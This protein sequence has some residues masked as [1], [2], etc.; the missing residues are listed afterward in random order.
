MN[1]HPCRLDFSSKPM[2]MGIINCTPDSFFPS[3]RT[4]ALTAAVKKA[5]EMIEEGAD[6]LDIGGE[7]SR[8]GADYINE[9]EELSRVIPAVKE[10]RKFSQIP[11]SIDTRK[12]EVARQA[13]DSGADI[14][15]DISALQDDA[16]LGTVVAG[17][18]AWIILM[19]KR[20]KPDTMQNNPNY[21][22][23]LA[24]IH[25]ELL[26]AVH[27]AENAG[28]S[29]KRIILDPGIGFGKRHEDNLLILNETGFFPQ[30]GVPCACRSFEEII[31]R[32]NNR[33]RGS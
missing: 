10:I 5:L 33:T 8:P 24:E 1:D 3:S 11:I 30:N 14:I 28:I 15:N 22:E 17:K 26:E 13:L 2:V 19:H 21:S 29:K 7:S 9:E 31:F 32:K 23:P 16:A 27:R 12:A 4:E 20:G 6:I 18:G 25:E